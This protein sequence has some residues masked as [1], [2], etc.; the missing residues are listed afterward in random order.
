MR[1]KWIFVR[2]EIYQ[3]ST[4]KLIRLTTKTKYLYSHWGYYKNLHDKNTFIVELVSEHN[5]CHIDPIT[6]EGEYLEEDSLCVASNEY[7]PDDD[8]DDDLDDDI[9]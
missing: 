4:C 2:D 6:V 9:W 8:F 5:T 1:H 3:C 7:D